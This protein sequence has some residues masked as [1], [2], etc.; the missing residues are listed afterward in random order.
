MEWNELVLLSATATTKEQSSKAMI[1]PVYSLALTAHAYLR[2]WK[3]F[4]V[5]ESMEVLT[6]LGG[7]IMK[8][9]ILGLL[10]RQIFSY[11]PGVIRSMQL[12]HLGWTFEPWQRFKVTDVKVGLIWN[13][14]IIC[15]GTGRL[16]V[17]KFP[18]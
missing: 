8:I 18:Q 11:I 14:H 16:R 5:K 12:A 4:H 6:S 1:A 9:I 15:G 17:S 2:D 13:V 7:P 3:A 10:Y